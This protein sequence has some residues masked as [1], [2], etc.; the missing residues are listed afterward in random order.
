[1]DYSQNE[2]MA[3]P[4]EG[5]RHPTQLY[6]SVKNFGLAGGLL[7]VRERIRP[8]PGL[9]TWLFVALYGWIRFGLMYVRDEERV[10]MDLTLSQIFSGLMGVLGAVMLIV[11]LAGRRDGTEAPPRGS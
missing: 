2:Y 5:C 4:P 9:I 8:R 3:R 1:V 6:Q 7:L 10:W 11:V